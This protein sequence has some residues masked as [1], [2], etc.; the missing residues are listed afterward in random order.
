MFFNIIK[1]TYDKHIANIILNEEQLKPFPL[2]FEMR[3]GCLLSPILFSIV[4]KFL[5]RSIRQEIK[6]IQIG[7][8]EVRLSLFADDMILYLK[9]SK[10]SIKKLLEI[11][12]SIKKLLT[13][14]QKNTM[15]K[16]LEII[17][18]IEK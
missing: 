9:G 15:K 16:L 6:G 14:Y 12:N 2:K 8:K 13:L 11:I 5:A 18:S 1:A 10:H 7:K 17:N 3:Q 4:F